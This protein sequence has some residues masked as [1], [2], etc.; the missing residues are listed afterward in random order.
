MPFLASSSMK[1][2]NKIARKSSSW[3]DSLLD[4]LTDQIA[5][6]RLFS[7]LQGILKDTLDNGIHSTQR[8]SD[9]ERNFIKKLSVEG[10]F[11]ELAVWFVTEKDLSSRVGIKVPLSNLDRGNIEKT[12]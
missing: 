7:V 12:P 11:P 10:I 3:A 6:T 2:K 9:P 8:T 4:E 5:G 1:R